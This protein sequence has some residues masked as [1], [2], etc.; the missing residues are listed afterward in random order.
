MLSQG[1]GWLNE[2]RTAVCMG[3]YDNT[4]V[5][6]YLFT[7]TK[8]NGFNLQLGMEVV[9]DDDFNTLK[10]RFTYHRIKG[11]ISISSSYRHSTCFETPC[12]HFIIFCVVG[13]GIY[14]AGKK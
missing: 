11:R 8:K 5:F 13:V 10:R 4:A 3:T 12:G 7:R 1:D 9:D 2:W 6:H 14:F